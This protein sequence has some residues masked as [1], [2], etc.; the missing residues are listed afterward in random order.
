MITK[1]I[2][3]ILTFVLL[4]ISGCSTRPTYS[5]TV[6]GSDKGAIDEVDY[7]PD[8]R[9]Q[10]VLLWNYVHMDGTD[11]YDI[12]NERYFWTIKSKPEESDAVIDDPNS[13]TPS[14][15]AGVQ[16]DY[17]IELVVIDE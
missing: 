17:V 3:I 4:L 5:P 9:P 7:A 15:H 8:N 6:P 13:P 11:V 10:T 12:E 16:G 14:F 2:N 1:Y